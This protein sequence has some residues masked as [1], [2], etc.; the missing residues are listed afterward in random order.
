MKLF[1]VSKITGFQNKQQKFYSSEWQTVTNHCLNSGGELLMLLSSRWLLLSRHSRNFNFT[2]VDATAPRQQSSNSCQTKIVNNCKTHNFCGNLIL[3]VGLYNYFVT[4]TFAFL[5]NK[6]YINVN[7]RYSQHVTFAN[8]SRSE[9]LLNK[10][11][12][13]IRV[14]Q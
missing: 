9:N 5:L 8:A 4:L 2:A 7:N 14:L 12:A 11:H 10:K 6:H 3:E 13:K 1:H